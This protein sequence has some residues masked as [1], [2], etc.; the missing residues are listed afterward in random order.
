VSEQVGDRDSREWWRALARHELLLQRCVACDRP[1]WPPRALCNGCGSFDWQWA[2]A[3]G[4]GT[5]ASWIVNHHSFGGEAAPAVVVLVR[6][7]EADDVLL[8][9]AHAGAADGSDL[10]VGLPVVA[11]FEDRTDGPTRVRWRHA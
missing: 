2:P 4:T 6:L 3:S 5:V 7:T 10:A 1:R 8:P 11:E 9:G